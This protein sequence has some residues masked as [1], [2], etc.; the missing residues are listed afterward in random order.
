MDT[1]KGKLINVNMQDRRIIYIRACA[2]GLFYKN[3]ND[4]N[5]VTNHINNSV[6]PYSYI[7]TVKQKSGFF[8]DSEVEGAR[9]VQLL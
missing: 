6:N 2:K 7:S 8:T 9:I 3:L 1:S 5:M 4:P